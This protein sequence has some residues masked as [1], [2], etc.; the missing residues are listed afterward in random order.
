MKKTTSLIIAISVFVIVS[1]S[2]FFFIKETFGP[3]DRHDDKEIVFIVEPGTPLNTL[4][5]NLKNANLI[6]NDLTLK[7]YAKIHPGVAQAGRYIL[8]K[9]MS[10]ID[11]YNTITSGKVTKDTIWMTFVEGKRLT[12]IAKTIS[13]NY[14]YT[15]EEILAKMDDRVFVQKMIDKYSVLTE[16]VLQNGIY[17]PLEGYLFPD[18]Y[19][20]EK[21]ATIEDIIETM[22]S[23]LDKK[24]SKY[25]TKIEESQYDIHEI[26]TLASM[27]ETE[28]GSA[29]DRKT[30]SG[31]FYNRLKAGMLLQSDPTTSY[32]V[33][34]E[35]S[36][37]IRKDEIPTCNPYNTYSECAK[38]IPI[39]PIAS[40]GTA[41][42][43]AA[44]DPEQH[45]YYYFVADKNG[46]TYFN[47]DLVGHNKTIKELQE[48]GL[49]YV[50]K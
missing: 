8:H 40:S 31:V 23:T 36:K 18:T 9:N 38:G 35:V 42:I 21:D 25:K 7:V 1:L 44:L 17:H 3:V 6:K 12:S 16:K 10:A 26:M 39:G 15:E 24:V 47:K 28:S 50:Y 2:A 5:Q 29:S 19:E 4:F 27:I 48:K 22:I 41:A 33:N 13:N 34:K 30:I 49:W 32:A 45:D 43:E 37:E 14:D 46:K 20:F 11:I